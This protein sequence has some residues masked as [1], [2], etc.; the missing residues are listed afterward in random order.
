MANIEVPEKVKIW[1]IGSGT[2]NVVS[3]TKYVDNKGYNL[4]CQA[5]GKYLT[6]KKVPIGINLDFINDA[7]VRKTHFQ[8]PDGTNRPILSGESI[9]LGIGGGDAFLEY[10]KRTLGINLSWSDNPEYEW[11]IFGSNSQI[12][13]PIK[14]NSL[15]AIFNDKVKPDPDFLIYFDR[16]R[17]MADV[18]WTSSPDFWNKIQNAAEKIAIEGA[19]KAATALVGGG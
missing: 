15:V 9:A 6:W 13:T 18:G 1:K 2:A 14:Q 4:F 12:G 17:G 19:K 16:A 11:R 10:D 3:T 5:N 8:V 7:S